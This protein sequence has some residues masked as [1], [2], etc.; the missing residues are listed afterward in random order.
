M[1][2]P[3]EQI[4]RHGVRVEEIDALAFRQA[5]GRFLTGVTVVTALDPAT[6]EARGMTA[7]AFMSVSL[8][9]PL[10]V[11]SLDRG[12]RLLATMNNAERFGVSILNE[13][14][15]PL[16]R[17]FAG[18]P[19]P[20]AEPELLLCSGVPVLADSLAYLLMAKADVYP[21]G[22]HVLFIGRIEELGYHERGTPLAYFGGHFYRITPTEADMLAWQSSGGELWM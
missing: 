11:V 7:S 13:N 17:H 1:A 22:D 8:D 5:L 20:D 9:P 21:A 4:P 12:S 19:D 14:Q 18:R 3:V 6:D 2:Q 16:A 15:A 10:A